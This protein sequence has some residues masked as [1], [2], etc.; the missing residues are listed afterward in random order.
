MLI[1]KCNPHTNVLPEYYNKNIYIQGLLASQR[2]R[3]T[4]EDTSQGRQ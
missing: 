1:V 4:A 2:K 3:I